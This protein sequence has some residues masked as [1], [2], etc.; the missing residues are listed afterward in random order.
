MNSN[1]IFRI[2]DTGE[3]VNAPFFDIENDYEVKKD[4]CLASAIAFEMMTLFYVVNKGR[5]F[6]PNFLL[7][8]TRLENDTSAV[9]DELDACPRK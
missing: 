1:S 5:E 7:Y 9:M 6:I 8:L 2:D 4:L 3:L